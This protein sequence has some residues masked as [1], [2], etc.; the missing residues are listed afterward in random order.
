LITI[1]DSR[2]S[3]VVQFSHFSVKEFL[4]SPRLLAS[5]QGV[6]HYHIV[7]EA[8]HGILAQACLAILLRSDD[9]IEE[10]GVEKN[11]PLAE[12]AAE[13][14][15]T[16]AQFEHA[17]FGI[18]KAMECL[19]DFDKPYFR[20]WI[21]LYDIDTRSGRFSTLRE[22][23]PYQKSDATPLYYAALCG[24][25]DLVGQL[26]LR[27]PHHVNTIGGHYMTPA[28]VALAGKHFQLAR[29]LHQNGSSVDLRGYCHC[30]PLH[31][32]AYIGDLETVR[33]LVDLKADISAV[34]QA[35][36]TPLQLA[37]I[38]G[39]SEVA[40]M[41]IEHGADVDAKDGGGQTPLQVAL[42]GGHDEMVKLL[43][44]YGA[45]SEDIKD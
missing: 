2:G 22:F 6:S 12:Y 14:W 10:N 9:Q 1:V 24:F 21:Q 42:G 33:V 37:S 34:A 4:V 15:V 18:R 19:F 30:S 45:K 31:C 32:A 43:L 29:L 23:A 3:K 41:L 20:H 17:S 27:Y 11:S 13:H 16:H 36:W 44:Q 26:I 39:H 8:A 7:V 35:F 25:E 38:G 5:T 28:V 40:R